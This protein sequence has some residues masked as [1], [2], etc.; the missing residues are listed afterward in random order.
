MKC[1][2][3][4]KG[5]NDYITYVDEDKN[6]IIIFQN[7]DKIAH[8]NLECSSAAYNGN[9]LLY[10]AK[11]KGSV[12]ITDL[13]NSY[14]K[15][16]SSSYDTLFIKQI[17]REFDNLVLAF[18]DGKYIIYDY[19]NNKE[20]FDCV[21]LGLNS[22]NDLTM[23]KYGNGQAVGFNKE[24]CDD[25]EWRFHAV[26]F[27]SNLETY[28]L[29][30]E[31]ATKY[32]LYEN[33]YERTICYDS[34]REEAN[35]PIFYVYNDAYYAKAVSEN[36]IVYVPGYEHHVV[37]I[38]DIYGKI[39]RLLAYPREISNNSYFAYNEMTD[40]VTI[41]TSKGEVYR[42]YVNTVDTALFEK[43][44]RIYDQKNY[45]TS[46]IESDIKDLL[47]KSLEQVHGVQESDDETY[48]SRIAMYNA[49]EYCRR[50]NWSDSSM[51]IKQD[52]DT[53]LNSLSISRLTEDVVEITVD[54]EFIMNKITDLYLKPLKK[55]FKEILGRDVNVDIKTDK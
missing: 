6:E 5:A 43:M 37:I 44:F 40:I 47:N 23:N 3:S 24:Y 4:S 52:F 21:N 51:L 53:L 48:I 9:R 18:A 42:W 10:T 35:F 31:L 36:Y 22:I 19:I 28:S 11:K 15:E 34:S 30:M 32:S 39:H 25:E 55:A 8:L 29:E 46:H 7:R 12:F 33:F 2:I 16:I 1:I 14:T 49:L 27:R 41:A 26:T 13:D 54:S 20:V 17:L 45:F 50:D 38:A